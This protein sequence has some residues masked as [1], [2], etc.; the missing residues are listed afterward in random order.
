MHSIQYVFIHS[1]SQKKLVRLDYKT[2]ESY[3]LIDL[4]FNIIDIFRESDVV[5]VPQHVKSDVEVV[6]EKIKIENNINATVEIRKE[7]VEEA[8]LIDIQSNDKQSTL[9]KQTTPNANVDQT[10]QQLQPQNGITLIIQEQPEPIDK[11]PQPSEIPPQPTEKPPQPIEKSPQP[12]EV[13]PQPVENP[14]KV[15]EKA[16]TEK[17][18]NLLQP[19]GDTDGM[20]EMTASMTKSRITTEEEAKAALAER[21]RLIREEAERQAELERLR[22][23]A[24]AKAELE[25]QQQ[26]EEQIRQL[27]ELQRQTEQERLQEVS[28]YY[29]FFVF[30]SIF[31]I[32]FSIGNKRNTKT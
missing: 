10:E 18:D 19:D 1:F 20:N 25:R 24:E 6:S 2:A 4:N 14:L 17:T 22:I 28:R 11:T 23:E 7:V 21:R 29:F 27:I 9:D 3:C 30:N 26:E 12:T 13:T 16:P 32:F 15:T 8:L 5:N 31:Y